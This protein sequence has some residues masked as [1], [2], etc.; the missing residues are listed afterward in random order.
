MKSPKVRSIQSAAVIHGSILRAILDGARAT[1]AE[2]TTLLK[3]VGLSA[4]ELRGE[5]ATI[6]LSRYLA[7]FE[8][9]AAS[10]K[11]PLLG[12]QIGDQSGP[13]LV[14]AIGYVF[15]G[16]PSLRLAIRL[17]VDGTFS[18]QGASYLRFEER[19]LPTLTYAFTDQSLGPWRQDVE[20][21][22]SYLNALIR[23][24]LGQDYAP[25]EVYLEHQ[26]AG[27]LSDYERVFRC[28]VYFDQERNALVL[29]EAELSRSSDRQD[30]RITSLLQHYLAMLAE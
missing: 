29:R 30:A 21:S 20:F 8:L 22:L 19:P 17:F 9:L 2:E 25:V 26:R 16:A 5:A 12:L 4:A 7:A 27:S 1:P 24:Y 15:L 10:R 18:I 14:G 11:Q 28:P 6:P 3:R 23:C 13:G